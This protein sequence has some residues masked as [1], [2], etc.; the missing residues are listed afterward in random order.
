MGN[1]PL[2]SNIHALF[3]LNALLIW[4][5]FTSCL[6][7]HLGWCSSDISWSP[8]CCILWCCIQPSPVFPFLFPI[9]MRC[10][11]P[12]C[13][14]LPPPWFITQINTQ[15]QTDK[16]MNTITDTRTCALTYR[17]IHR[18]KHV[19]NHLKGRS[20]LPVCLWVRE[21]FTIWTWLLRFVPGRVHY[22]LRP[23]KRG[24]FRFANF[25]PDVGGKCHFH[26]LIHWVLL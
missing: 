13:L 15:I 21:S 1:A 5:F 14:A 20:G 24:Q 2:I 16:P 18:Y 23:T 6:S 7:F 12:P 3:P 11:G 26:F 10:K 25:A 17:H 8:I 4:N 9:I 19:S 22:R